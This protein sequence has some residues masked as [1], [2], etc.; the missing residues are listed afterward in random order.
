M[1]RLLR[2]GFPETLPLMERPALIALLSLLLYALV[3][4]TMCATAWAQDASSA[5]DPPAGTLANG[6]VTSDDIRNDQSETDQAVA[7]GGLP[8]PYSPEDEPQVFPDV[9][10][11]KAKDPKFKVGDDMEQVIVAGSQTDFEKIMSQTMRND[12]FFSDPERFEEELQVSR[13]RVRADSFYRSGTGIDVDFN[14]RG[15]FVFP[16]TDNRLVLLLSGDFDRALGEEDNPQQSDIKS[17][18]EPDDEREDGVLALQGFLAATDR[19]NVSIQAGGRFRDGG[20]IAFVGPRYRQTFDIGP[21]GL[22]RVLLQARWFTDE[23]AAVTSFVDFDRRL[24]DRLFLRVTPRADWSE[25]EDGF[26]YG[27]DMDLAQDFGGEQRLRYQLA[28]RARTQPEDEITRVTFR[29]NYR[30]RVLGNWLYMEVAPEISLLEERDFE[31]TPGLFIRGDVILG[32]FGIN[33]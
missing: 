15:R 24:S 31:V 28:L 26:F 2:A 3:V 16:N 8:F 9:S 30:R 6:G 1:C 13:L 29:L 17:L 22:M 23:G 10:F 7:D 18:L 4:D 12:S 32:P 5:E 20:P 25:E 19:L 33:F 11:T 14:L 21:L 27:L